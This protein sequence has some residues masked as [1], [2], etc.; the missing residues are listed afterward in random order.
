MRWK[1][2]RREGGRRCRRNDIS[3][4]RR[5]ERRGERK[6]H[7]AHRGIQ[8]AGA[9]RS[10][11]YGIRSAAIVFGSDYRSNFRAFGIASAMVIY[12]RRGGI[13]HPRDPAIYADMV[14]GSQ[15]I[16]SSWP[17]RSYQRRYRIPASTRSA[18]GREKAARAEAAPDI[19]E[20]QSARRADSIRTK[21]MKRDYIARAEEVGMRGGDGTPPQTAV[22]EAPYEV[23]I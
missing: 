16:D 15:H 19:G 14:A 23:E 12:R 17:R 18:L 5:G 20:D 13:C 21:Q 10:G 3:A 22:V 1:R 4:D 7:P 8:S 11:L 9:R 6:R 2:K